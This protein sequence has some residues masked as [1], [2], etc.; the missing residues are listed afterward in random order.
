MPSTLHCKTSAWVKVTIS[1][2]LLVQQCVAQNT[3]VEIKRKYVTANHILDYHNIVNAFGHVSIR[4]PEDNST[5]IMAKGM[6]SALVANDKDLAHYYVSDAY[7]VRPQDFGRNR[8]ERFIHSEILKRFSGLNSC[9][10]AHTTA[11]LPYATSDVPFSPVY[12]M[13]GYLGLNIPLWDILP[14]YNSTDVQDNL[15]TQ[16]RFG[17]SLAETFGGNGTFP[18]HVFVLMKQ[19]GFT[20]CATTIEDAIYQAVYAKDA[21]LAELGQVELREA[22]H[23]AGVK[24]SGGVET[25]SPEQV[26][27]T[28]N[29]P[30]RFGRQTPWE[31]WARQVEADPLYE[32]RI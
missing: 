23:G 31:L 22:Y 6:A 3:L 7:P 19:H 8:S 5:F 2:L 1:F 15:V 16:P 13:V 20:T 18:E 11:V 21:A 12:H 27:G 4:N 28:K 10:H 30:A 17:A 24:S 25:L 14:L 26:E 29:F 9:V 32:N